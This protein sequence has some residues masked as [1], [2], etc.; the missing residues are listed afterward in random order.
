MSN[1]NKLDQIFSSFEVG[2]SFLAAAVTALVG[3]VYLF[4]LGYTSA[5]GIPDF[6]SYEAS[7][8]FFIASGLAKL[9]TPHH[10]GIETVDNALNF[11]PIILA[12]YVGIFL[13]YWLK[14]DKRKNVPVIKW[15]IA[16]SIVLLPAIANFGISLLYILSIVAPLLIFWPIFQFLTKPTSRSNDISVAGLIG[17]VALTTWSLPYLVGKSTLLLTLN[18]KSFPSALDSTGVKQSKL[19]WLE[20]D[21]RFWLDCSNG[22]LRGENQSG[23]VFIYRYSSNLVYKRICGAK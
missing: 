20:S 15:G 18:S 14:R 23:E 16:S 21:K 9:S 2:K 19:V 8:K 10:T 7:L 17:I 11:Y 1:G 4:S 12:L 3:G 6:P 22:Y 5:L 13:A